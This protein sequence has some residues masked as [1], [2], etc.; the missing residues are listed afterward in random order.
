V[1]KRVLI[2]VAAYLVLAAMGGRDAMGFLSGSQPA[3]TGVP[4]LG[5]GYFVAWFAL[6]LVAPVLTIAAALSA[7]YGRIIWLRSWI[8]SRRR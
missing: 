8:A 7:L 4:L 6:W 3:G 1:I 2:I 5:A